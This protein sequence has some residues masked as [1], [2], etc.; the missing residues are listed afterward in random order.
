[1]KYATDAKISSFLVLI[2]ERAGFRMVK[3]PEGVAREIRV[4]LKGLRE[5]V[6]S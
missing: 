4:K 2:V 5:V 6:F 1:M 3:A